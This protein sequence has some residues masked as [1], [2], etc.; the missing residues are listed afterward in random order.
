MQ[1][2]CNKGRLNKLV[3]VQVKKLYEDAVIPT[4]GS[5]YAAGADLYAYLPGEKLVEIAPHETVMIGSGIAAS[6]PAEY[7]GGVFAR[8]GLASKQGLSPAN[9]VGV[10]DPDYRGEIKIALH[11]HSEE[12]RSVKHGDRIAQLVIVPLPRVLY[13]AVS[14]LDDTKRGDGGFGH[15]GV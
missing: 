12:M 7:W 15:T 5:D 9:K 8:S 4:Q 13:E 10:V 1:M 2:N 14:E 11:N 6:I 3:T